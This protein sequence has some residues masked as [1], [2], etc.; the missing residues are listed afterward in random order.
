M[1]AAAVREPYPIPSQFIKFMYFNRLSSHPGCWWQF[2]SASSTVTWAPPTWCRIR[3]RSRFLAASAA[4]AA[5]LFMAPMEASA[6]DIRLAW[7]PSPGTVAGY[8]V[9]WGTTQGSYPNSANAGTQTTWTVQ[10]LTNGVRYYFMV[11]AYSSSGTESS[12]SNEV[13]GVASSPSFTDDPLVPGVHSMRL[14]HINELRTR[15]DALRVGRSL[16]PMGWT[17]LVAGT[18]RI[19]AAHITQMRAAINAV[20]VAMQRTLPVYTD[21]PLTPGTT[22]K[23]AHIAQLRAAVKALEP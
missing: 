3:T 10:G 5:A 20:Y 1:V 16:T 4:V 17:S 18:T 9:Y 8:R 13:N 19:S 7:D 12:N 21:D 2:C 11:R 14:L 22:I 15:I 6:A 23:A